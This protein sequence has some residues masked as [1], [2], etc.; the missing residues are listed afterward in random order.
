[1]IAGADT[2]ASTLTSVFSCLLGNR[3]AYDK[4]EAE[5]DR[6]FPPGE[7]ALSTKH[8][9]DMHYLTAVMYVILPI[10]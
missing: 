1:M 3:D 2:T 7:D 4:L 8:H 10:L 6:F 5:V 9:K